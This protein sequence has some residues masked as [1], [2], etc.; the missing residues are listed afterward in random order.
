MVLHSPVDYRTLEW[1]DKVRPLGSCPVREK[2][3]Y[4]PEDSTAQGGCEGVAEL[5]VDEMWNGTE[6]DEDEVQTSHY[7]PPAYDRSPLM[8]TTMTTQRE[9]MM[10]MVMTR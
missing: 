10:R 7:H 4:S 2:H 1:P 3:G 9:V 5:A 8:K 6:T